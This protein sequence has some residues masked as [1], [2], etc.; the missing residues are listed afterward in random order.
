MKEKSVHNTET[1]DK[2]KP[3]RGIYVVLLLF[4][5]ALLLVII[6]RGCNMKFQRLDD[7]GKIN[8]YQ[9]VDIHGREYSQEDFKGKVMIFINLQ[10]ECLD[11]CSIALF[12][13]E[14]IIYQHIR[15]RKTLKDYQ[16]VAFIN[17]KQG[18]AVEDLTP[19]YELLRDRIHHYDP[20]KWLLVKGD[21]RQVYNIEHNG[22]NLLQKGNQYFGGNAFQ[23]L[24]LLV[25]KENHLRMVLRGNAEGMFRRLK[26]CIALLQKEYRDEAE[27]KAS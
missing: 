16:I 14:K 27:K 11:T 8:N 24:M 18:N 9:F 20:E 7:F 13:F 12:T 26:Q 1:T 17:D 15:P 22:Q 21:A 2:I 5:P 23:E 3:K 6:G 10:N 4:A 25:D 19:M